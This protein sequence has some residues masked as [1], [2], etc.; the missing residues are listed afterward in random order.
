[1]RAL[2]PRREPYE[3]VAH[4]FDIKLADVRLIAAHAWD[5]T[6]ALAAGCTAAFVARPGMALSPI[7][8]RPDIVGADIDDVATQIIAAG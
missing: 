7:G 1:M 6:G 4:T 8:A 5:I 3:L 2:K